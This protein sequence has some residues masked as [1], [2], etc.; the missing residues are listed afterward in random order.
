ME[1]QH[2]YLIIK[3]YLLFSRVKKSGLNTTENPEAAEQS[4]GGDNQYTP[5]DDQYASVDDQYATADDQYG[6]TDD[7]YGPA[8]DQYGPA[9]DQY[10]PADD[11]YPAGDNQYAPEDTQYTEEDQFTWGWAGTDFSGF[12]QDFEWRNNQPL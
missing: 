9:D 12:S 10:G 5:A 2:S 3:V 8:D 1:T 6:P 4:Y 11:Q 7:Q